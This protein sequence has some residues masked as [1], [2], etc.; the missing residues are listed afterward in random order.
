VNSEP[1]FYFSKPKI[2]YF[3]TLTD[4]K[5]LKVGGIVGDLDKDQYVEF[6]VMCSNPPTEEDMKHWDFY[7]NMAFEEI[8][9]NR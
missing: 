3:P 7:R 5:L 8:W 9:K 1:R 2:G 6:Y 4:K